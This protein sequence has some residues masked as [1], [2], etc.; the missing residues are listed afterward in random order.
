M[1]DKLKIGSLFYQIKD[2]I[3]ASTDCMVLENRDKVD[4]ELLERFLGA[5]ISENDSQFL[6]GVVK[7]L[8]KNKFL[9][10]SLN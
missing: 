7:S 6:D 3:N 5:Q 8:P 4:P 1:T 10:L 9:E 2:T